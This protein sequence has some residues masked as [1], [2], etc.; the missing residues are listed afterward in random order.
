MQKK[1]STLPFAGTPEQEAQLKAVIAENCSDKSNLMVVM[2]KAQDIYGYL[3]MEVQEM[4][5]EGMDVPLEKVYGVAT[6]FAHFTLK[7][8]GKHIIK[9][10]DGT[11]CHVKRSTTI[12][13]AIR[14]KLNLTATENTTKDMLFTLET[15]SCLGACGLAPAMVID[16][17]V[18]G[19]VTP[20]KVTKIIDDMIKQEEK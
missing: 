10:C 1:I 14:S 7:A 2:Q 5:A 3:P 11:A 18:Y 8:K 17:E 20:E 15:V 16:N 4:I 9:V 6:F 13:D 19:Q 12:I